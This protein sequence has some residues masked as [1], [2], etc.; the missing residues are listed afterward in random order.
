MLK[1][2]RNTILILGQGRGELQCFSLCVYWTKKFLVFF[3]YYLFIKL[4]NKTIYRLGVQIILMM[5][6]FCYG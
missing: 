2:K 3:F 1:Q 4:C 6:F 5:V